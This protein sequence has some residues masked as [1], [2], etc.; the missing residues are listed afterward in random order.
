M[1]NKYS[2]SGFSV[3]PVYKNA[4]NPSISKW[5]QY[6]TTHPA[7]DLINAW[8]RQFSAGQINIGLACGKASNIIA[9][10]IDSDDPELLNLCPP[11]PVRKRGSK[12]ETRFFKYNPNIKSQSYPLLDILSDG[13]Q[14]ILPPST[15][16]MTRQPY[17]WLT[18]DTLLDQIELPELSL[19]FIIKFQRQPN[20]SISKEGR[21]NKLVD[22]IT[23]MRGRGEPE[24]AI[25]NEVYEWDLQHHLPRLFMDPKEQY[26]AKR[27]K[28]ES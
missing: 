6:C 4:K 25:V 16:P 22:I 14:T 26:K 12:G 20:A 9:L 17:V 5:Q 24:S 11:S 19:D 13:R 23:A 28:L 10:D 18:L 7:Q 1:F 27:I 2:E 15:H 8:D 3:I 21:N